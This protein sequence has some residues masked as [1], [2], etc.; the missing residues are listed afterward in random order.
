MVDHICVVTH[1]DNMP[2]YSFFYLQEPTVCVYTETE[3]SVINVFIL[4]HQGN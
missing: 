1:C 4:K 2:W 3:K